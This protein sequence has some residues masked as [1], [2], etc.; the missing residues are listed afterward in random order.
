M[1]DFF[2]TL[3]DFFIFIL[4]LKDIFIRKYLRIKTNCTILQNFE[5][6]SKPTIRLKI[7]ISYLDKG[8]KP[9]DF[10]IFSIFTFN[11]IYLRSH[12]TSYWVPFTNVNVIQQISFMIYITDTE[13]GKYMYYM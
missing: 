1:K 4:I 2:I 5:N 3:S 6:I 13:G 12:I 9:P 11:V 7:C 8:I 10:T